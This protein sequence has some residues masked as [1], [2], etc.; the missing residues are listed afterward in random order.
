MKERVAPRPFITDGLSPPG[1]EW[2]PL[3]CDRIT[4][5]FANPCRFLI[6]RRLGIELGGLEEVMDAREPFTLERLDRYRLAERLLHHRMSD[7]DPRLL[8]PVIRAEGLLPH[9]TVGAC[10]FQD[11]CLETDRFA[12]TI[13]PFLDGGPP[14]VAEGTIA[15]S[16]GVLA[17]RLT[18]LYRDGMF[19]YRYALIT[20][21]DYLSAWIRHL[22]L[23]VTGSDGA[24]TRTVV[25]GMETKG[26]ERV[27]SVWEFTPVD[28][29]RALLEGLFTRY[30][31][32]LVRPLHFFPSSSGRYARFILEKGPDA[33]E[34]LSHARAEWT[35]D[36]HR[37]G[38]SEDRYY[39]LCFGD[40][41]PLDREFEECSL[42]LFTPLLQH[43]RKVE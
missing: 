18:D 25:A 8:L 34:A 41:D 33:R 37:R 26:S 32:G 3:D 6:T 9:G 21:R 35:G 4:E 38:E 7:N 42:A 13:R 19:L 43:L 5:F 31:E 17:Y 23:A 28:N 36:D 10:T 15:L 29:A 22:V 2:D 12:E 14:G 40:T 20:Q 30:R 16:G 1:Q 24:P 11:L 39:T 27:T